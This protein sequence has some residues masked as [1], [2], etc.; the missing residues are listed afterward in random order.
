MPHKTDSVSVYRDLSG[1]C[2][3]SVRL[4]VCNIYR[5]VVAASESTASNADAKRVR[6]V[7]CSQAH[8]TE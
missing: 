2:E 5:S 4:D 3:T 1:L 7:L 6:T 8:S